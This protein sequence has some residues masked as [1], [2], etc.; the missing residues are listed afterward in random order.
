MKVKNII[1]GGDHFIYIGEAEM[2]NLSENQN[3][4]IYHNSKIKKII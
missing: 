1:E 3:P 2:G 4:L